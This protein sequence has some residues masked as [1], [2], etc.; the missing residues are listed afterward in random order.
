MECW[1]VREHVCAVELFIQMRSITE[2]Q[3]GFCSEQNQQKAPSTHAICRWVRRWHEE[4]SVTCKKP[5]GW[6]S[7]VRHLPK[8]PE[9]WLPSAAVGGD[10]HVSTLK[11]YACLIG[12]YGPSCI[13]ILILQPYKLQVVHALSN[14]VERCTCNF[15]VSVWKY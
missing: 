1:G 12:V 6:W 8:L 3:R 13:L 2:N 14:R 5:P 10:L 9:C 7:S 11:P 4:G 15:V